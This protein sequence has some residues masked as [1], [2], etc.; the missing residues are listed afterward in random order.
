MAEY[1][2]EK[3]RRAARAKDGGSDRGMPPGMVYLPPKG[4]KGG[5]VLD[6]RAEAEHIARK[7]G[8]GQH[9]TGLAGQY[10]KGAPFVGQYVDEAIGVADEAMGG[11]PG[12]MRERAR[13]NQERFETDHPN[14]SLAANV[15]GGVVTAA[16]A[17]GPLS[18]V[19]SFRSPAANIAAGGVTGAALGTAE[20][21][22]SGYGAG[23]TADERR[24]NAETGAM[25]G[26]AVGGV[27][28]GVAPVIFGG[29]QAVA[30]NIASGA[31]RRTAEEIG[32]SP[33]S[34][35]LVGRMLRYDDPQDAIRNIRQGGDDAM[36]AD[37]GPVSQGLLDATIQ[38]AGPGGAIAKKNIGARTDRAAQN[39]DMAINDAFGRPPAPVAREGSSKY[40]ALYDRAYSKP[41]DY[42]TDIGV[43]LEG[44]IQNVPGPALKYANELMQVRGESS[45]QIKLIV[46]E[47]GN[48]TG[49]QGLP[50]V[51]QWD[52]I[53]RALNDVAKGGDGKGVLGGNTTRG[54]AYAALS[55][56]IRKRL[57]AA[58]PEWKVAVDA[59][60]SDVSLKE[61]REIG[62]VALRDT[63]SRDD[64]REALADMG[65]A[66]RRK[67][68]AGVRQYI[69][70]TLSS[71][72][73]TMTDPRT[74]WREAQKLLTML[75]SRQAKDKL[76]MMLGDGPA[77]T[78]IGRLQKAEKAFE[79]KAATARNSATAGRQ[80]FMETIKTMVDPGVMG[81]LA[82]GEVGPASKRI[83]QE[84]TAMT[85]A[86]RAEVEERLAGEI[87]SILTTHQGPAAEAAARRLTAMLE[88]QPQTE[89]L[90]GLIGRS[91]AGAV[92]LTGYAAGT[93]A[94][95]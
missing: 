80:S 40:K 31:D 75:S 43:E 21:A 38:A 3:H 44:L 48:V 86:R 27:T 64:L 49:M 16:P 88:R 93:T 5:Y 85:P 24:R 1:D 17:V 9:M 50:D 15:T 91:V 95:E 67:M 73:R 12:L 59:V 32:G 4:D 72:K 65:L 42:A 30:K 60:A 22:V 74:D 58:V 76:K 90:A 19:T 66:E 35:E 61:A 89:R 29:G 46:D 94:L 71:V 39:I 68:A 20:G 52:Y 69:D 23:R 92:G 36:L 18:R 54:A 33:E 47:A 45:R 87:A 70:D 25:I 78:L 62:G 57:K 7:G 82:Q 83:I 77:Q 8:L 10:V 28:G 84:M 11:T 63:T 81:K 2:P 13:A 41:I 51:R 53:T 55:R 14:Q 6:T 56:Q 79:L 34:A 37:A 26:G